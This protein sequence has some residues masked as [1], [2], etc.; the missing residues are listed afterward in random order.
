MTFDI[1]LTTPEVEK[2]VLKALGFTDGKLRP[3]I[4]MQGDH[5]DRDIRPTL[6][7]FLLTSPV[8]FTRVGARREDLS[9]LEESNA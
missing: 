9:A 2:L 3:K 6:T 4:E 1:H 7:G 8:P 5:M